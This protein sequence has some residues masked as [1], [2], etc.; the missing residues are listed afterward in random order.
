VCGIQYEVT[1]RSLLDNGRPTKHN[2]QGGVAAGDATAGLNPG[3]LRRDTCTY[4]STTV[5]EYM[6]NWKILRLASSH[7]GSIV[8]DLTG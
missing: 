8:D 7:A 1:S 6:P 2:T 5:D 3:S 4:V